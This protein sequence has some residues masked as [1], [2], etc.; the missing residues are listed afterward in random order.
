[1]KISSRQQGGATILDF[2]G[3]ITLFN[4]PEIRKALLEQLRDKRVPFF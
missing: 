1:M 3:D 4:S 2:A